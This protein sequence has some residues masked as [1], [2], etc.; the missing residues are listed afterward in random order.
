MTC[1]GFFDGLGAVS[2]TEGRVRSLADFN[3]DLDWL[4]VRIKVNCTPGLV[5]SETVE[6]DSVSGCFSAVV[7]TKCMAGCSTN[8][9]GSMG[10]GAG[11]MT[12]G[13]MDTGT[14]WPMTG[15]MIGKEGLKTG[16]G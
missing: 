16:K 9:D 11:F 15:F 13:I 3:S 4:L 12:G 14:N 5:L 1:K 7:G 10:T 8:T 2:F 6:R